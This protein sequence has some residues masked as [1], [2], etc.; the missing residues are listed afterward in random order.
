MTRG[1]ALSGASIAIL[2]LGLSSAAA[3]DKPSRMQFTVSGYANFA[4]AYVDQDD[5]GFLSLRDVGIAAEAEVHFKGRLTLDNGLHFGFRAE[6]ELNR[7]GEYPGAFLTSDEADLIDEVYVTAQDSWG[8][9]QA[10]SQDGV[11]DQMG[12][13][14]PGVSRA[15]RVSDGEIYFF[16]DGYSDG[17]FRPLPLRTDLYGSDDNLKVVYF[18]PRIAGF[19]FGVSYTPE[20]TKGFSGTA[21]R[22]DDDFNQQGDF[23]ELG[24]S[25][26]TQIEGV[27]IAAA[28]TYLTASNEDPEYFGSRLGYGDDL[29]E[30]HFGAR[31]GFA[32]GDFRIV[33]GGS[34]RQ[35]NAENGIIFSDG[36]TVALDAIDAIVWDA[37]FTLSR[38]PWTIGATYSAGESDIIDYAAAD[39]L[40]TQEGH[41]W[42]FSLGFVPGPGVHL[43]LG[44]QMIT[45][46]EEAVF[47][48]YFTGTDKAEADVVFLETAL[49]L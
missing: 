48:S 36:Y 3:K 6:L 47:P 28:L 33:A 44:Y 13:F 4:V 23:I 11:A 25:Y 46:E 7:S 14:A 38:G 31:A 42:E 5:G 40:G 22:A 49:S 41:G 16:Q 29:E 45:Y 2:L 19:Q 26:R 18:T 34:I 39:D 37:G 27:D 21:S 43:T 15:T 1:L 32:L 8:E 20:A 35:S 30:L 10:G 24:L 12:V 9:I 17:E